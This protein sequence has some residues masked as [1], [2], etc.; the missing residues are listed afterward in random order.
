MIFFEKII[1]NNLDFY[2]K[3][4]YNVLVTTT[5][6]HL[7]QQYMNIYSNYTEL[8]HISN[9]KVDKN[10]T[11]NYRYIFNVG[12]NNVPVSVDRFSEIKENY[13]YY[14]SRGGKEAIMIEPISK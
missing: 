12:G 1:Q 11:I 13:K 2:K 7:K 4:C 6:K 9:R 14:V 5:T 3:E 10:L 8:P